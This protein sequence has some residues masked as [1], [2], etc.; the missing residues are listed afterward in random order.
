MDT[1]DLSIDPDGDVIFVLSSGCFLQQ[2]PDRFCVVPLLEKPH[3]R[4]QL[5]LS[6]SFPKK[7]VRVASGHL[8]LSSSVFKAM[9]TGRT[10]EGSTL[11]D[12]GFVRIPLPDDYPDG[13]LIILYIIH[14]KFKLMPE[15][16]TPSLLMQVVLLADK[17]DLVDV[18]VPFAQKWLADVQAYKPWFRGA[19]NLEWITIFK[20][21]GAVPEF[22]N[23]TRMELEESAEELSTLELPISKVTG[24][25]YQLYHSLLRNLMIA[26]RLYPPKQSQSSDLDFLSFAK[27]YQ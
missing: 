15:K 16:I 5:P 12:S 21:L 11:R 26:P 13:L 25:F 27:D 3:P 2:G 4:K 8:K 14:C 22:M 7:T 19:E 6:V 24:K 1:A 9:L 10:Y 20:V 18:L 17:Y 23:L